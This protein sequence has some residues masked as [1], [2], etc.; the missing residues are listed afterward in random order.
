MLDQKYVRWAIKATV[1]L[2]LLYLTSLVKLGNYFFIASALYWV[3]TNLGQIKPGEKSAYSIFNPNNE[4]LL[5]TFSG[6]EW[7]KPFGGT[8]ATTTPS[9]PEHEQDMKALA[10]SYYQHQSKMANKPCYCGSS[11][12]YKRCCLLKHEK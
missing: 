11:L 9:N 10:D 2:A 1:W 7:L 4:K 12:K 3:F 5:G 8:A 6:N